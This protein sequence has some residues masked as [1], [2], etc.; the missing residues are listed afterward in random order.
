MWLY[1]SFVL[2]MSHF[3]KDKGLP[4]FEGLIFRVLLCI[5]LL[6]KNYR[7]SIFVFLS[8]GK[9]LLIKIFLKT[10]S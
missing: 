9:F 6:K 3:L 1:S 2:G 7:P 5:A 8:T 10:L 4:P